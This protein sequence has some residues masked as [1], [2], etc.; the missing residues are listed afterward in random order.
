GAAYCL[1]QTRGA[2]AVDV[3]HPAEAVAETPVHG[4]VDDRVAVRERVVEDRALAQVALDEARGRRHPIGTTVGVHLR[5]EVVEDG[6]RVPAREQR[7]DDVAADESGASSDQH[8]HGTRNEPHGM[9]L[10][11]RVAWSP[12]SI[13]TS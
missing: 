1:E 4:L 2:R 13:R 3:R 7:V 5:L 6:D 8:A 9:P 10:V 12:K 11:N